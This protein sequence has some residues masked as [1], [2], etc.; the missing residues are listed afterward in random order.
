MHY[1]KHGTSPRFPVCQWQIPFSCVSLSTRTAS[2]RPPVPKLPAAKKRPR[3]RLQVPVLQPPVRLKFSKLSSYSDFR[4]DLPD[5]QQSQD[6]PR[7]AWD[8]KPWHQAMVQLQLQGPP[9]TPVY[10][11][12][13]ACHF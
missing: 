3:H 11:T 12:A 10:R 9:I 6:L 8:R 1:H 7:L 13:S 5:R 4:G 2:L